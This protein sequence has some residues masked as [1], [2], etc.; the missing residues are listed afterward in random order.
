MSNLS[1][2]AVNRRLEAAAKGEPVRPIK[3]EA[4][5][6]ILAKTDSRIHFAWMTHR[7]PDIDAL[8]KQQRFLG[9][10]PEG[11]GGPLFVRSID[12]DAACFAFITLWYCHASCD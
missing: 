3:A 4:S 7:T 11:Y 10:P 2:E 8:M 12:A 1:R 9:Y 6:V 5:A